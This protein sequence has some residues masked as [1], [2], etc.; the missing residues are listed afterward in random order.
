MSIIL[1][2]PPFNALPG[3]GGNGGRGGDGGGVSVTSNGGHVLVQNDAQIVINGDNST[4]ILAQSIGGGGGIGT[5]AGLGGRVGDPRS[6]ALA[7]IPIA[8]GGDNG[9]NGTGGD[10]TVNN[11]GTL[12]INGANS[13]GIFAQS[14]GGGGGRASID[15]GAAQLN[16]LAGGIGNGGVVAVQNT[17]SIVVNGS[18]SYAY[19]A[20]S[21]GGG[22]G[23]VSC[24]H[25][26]T[27]ANACR[28]PGAP[29][30]AGANAFF[31]GSAGGAGDAS[32]LTLSQRGSLIATGVD[33]IALFAQSDASG[34]RGDITIDIL[35]LA[36]DVMSVIAGGSGTGAGVKI[37]G[38]ADNVLNNYGI[39]T[40][41]PGVAGRA[42]IGDIG[43]NT[44]NNF[45]RV[46][47]SVDLGTG[48]GAFNN[49]SGAVFL[50]GP[51]IN[52]GGGLLSNDGL[53]APGGAGLV[54]TTAL[55]GSFVQSGTGIWL[56][57][58]DNS[59]VA[60]AA[61]RIDAS[62]TGE[63]AGELGLNLANAGFTKPG[64]GQVTLLSTAGGLTDSGL[65]LVYRPSAIANYQLVYPTANEL[66]LAYTIDFARLRDG[67]LNG[68]Q[69]AIG[70][71]F[72]RV[73]LAGG[74]A[75]NAPIVEVL[76]AF[77]DAQD[78]ANAYDHL[79]PEAYVG[80]KLATW[81]SSARF[82]QA[83]LDC[84]AHGGD[85]HA[86]RADRCAWAQAGGSWLHQESTRAN[87]GYSQET[88]SMGGGFQRAL[89]DTWNLGFGMNFES[90]WQDV[91]GFSSGQ[92]RQFQLGAVASA[93]FGES[94]LSWAMDA[95]RG[96]YD[97]RR[98]VTLPVPAVAT[99]DSALSFV[100][101]RMR[102]AHTLGGPAR[103]LRP[104]L[105]VG[106]GYLRS[107]A[108]NEEG[109]GAAGLNVRAQGETFFSVSSA[110]EF[111]SESQSARSSRVRPFARVGLTG[112]FAGTTP[113]LSAT[114]QGAPDGVAPF[115]IAGRHDDYYSDIAL[116]L[117][118]LDVGGGN[119]RLGYNG[120]FSDG[121]FS[122][123][124]VFI[125]ASF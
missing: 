63:L 121:N 81:Q 85:L 122:Y 29:G 56:A 118:I 70:D 3:I 94:S 46:I 5:V 97:I 101:A 42:V 102:V 111:G 9:A 113:D 20:Q 7:A 92:A 79:S 90:S 76:L 104:M 31:A 53:F 14:V 36:P 57:D 58:F 18:N 68:N 123:S 80:R 78:V 33:S 49:A 16:L 44:I 82:A 50:A 67:G 19:F 106:A 35:N 27:P 17:G 124:A 39:I 116:G 109:A 108:F 98:Q 105:D 65:T 1:P 107:N 6:L 114:L 103:Y 61:D 115:A 45:G 11:T 43:N 38:G 41:A 34:S 88:F 13:F 64:S 54:Q 125:K 71:Y 96:L 2:V 32:A 93:Q 52:L 99:S 40:S 24:N 119:L 91:A 66:S 86:A 37:L 55:N 4:G 30:S 60:A 100:T 73:Q 84:R 89:N 15:G 117:D 10:V 69:M 74:S 95:G 51:T 110:L 87:F 25:V 12:V 23:V 120:Q 77:A 75:G 112:L 72:N 83:M 26:A 22:G 59:G 21:I 28:F 48:L 47:G 8:I 62:G